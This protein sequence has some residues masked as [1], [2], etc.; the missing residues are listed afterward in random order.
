MKSKITLLIL[1]I[2]TVLIF[3][4]D[5]IPC[6]NTNS[7]FDENSPN[8]KVYKD[9]LIKQL[10][11]VN[12]DKLSYWF[13]EFIEDQDQEILHFYIQGDGLCAKIALNVEEWGELKHLRKVKG[14][15]YRGA[16]FINL[17]FDS[18]QDSL[19][20]KFVYRGHKKIID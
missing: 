17:K 15:S 18:H 10:K 19:N 7:V 6:T 14:V 4:C 12:E 20:T 2:F 3:S 11:S 1:S 13:A 5:R 8:S 16:E 9:E